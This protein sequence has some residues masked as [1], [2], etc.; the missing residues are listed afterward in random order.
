[1]IGALGLLY[2]SI[3]E[4][5]RPDDVAHLLL[6]HPPFTNKMSGMKGVDTQAE[7]ID[8]AVALLRKLLKVPKDKG[9]SFQEWDGD[10]TPA[11]AETLDTVYDRV[12]RR[13]RRR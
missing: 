3:A 13:G 8:K 1:M 4:R 6:E 5:W 9:L 11:Q 7:R 2:Q 12:T 10:L